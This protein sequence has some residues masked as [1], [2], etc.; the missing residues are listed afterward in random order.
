MVT[1]LTDGNFQSTLQQAQ[2]PVLVDF[3]ASWCQ[4]CKALAPTIDKVADD[5]FACGDVYKIDT[6]GRSSAG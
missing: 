2:V 4:P 6:I 3:S 5:I 1:E